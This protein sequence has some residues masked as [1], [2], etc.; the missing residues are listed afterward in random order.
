MKWHSFGGSK[1]LKAVKV[2]IDIEDERELY[3]ISGYRP[4]KLS[5]KRTGQLSIR[6]NVQFR[7]IYSIERD[8]EG[9]FV[10]IIELVDYH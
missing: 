6:L 4:E 5:G 10:Y 1:F 2:L 8:Q 9:R 7:L 3:S